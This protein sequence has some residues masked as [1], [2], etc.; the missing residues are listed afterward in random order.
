LGDSSRNT[1]DFLKISSGSSSAAS[2][3]SAD[4]T[5]MPMPSE[6]AMDLSQDM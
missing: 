2:A 4:V 3:G 6:A 5:I 1:V